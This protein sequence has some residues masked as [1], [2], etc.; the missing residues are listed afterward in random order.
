MDFNWSLLLLPFIAATIGWFTNYVAVKM[1]FNPKE[2]IKIGFFT[3][4]GIFPKRQAEI[5]VSVGKMV[6]KDLL[7]SKDLQERLADKE[8]IRLIIN[9]IEDTLDEYFEI[10]FPEKFPLLSKIISTKMRTRVKD[11]MLD[12]VELLAPQLIN[13]Q[14]NQLDKVFDVEEIVTEKVKQL[15]TEK[16]EGLMMSIIEKE[17]NFIEWVGAVLGFF[18]GLL[19]V[20]WVAIF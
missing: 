20:I 17:L 12:E 19:Q 13:N 10:K 5:A 4:H 6:A 8:N 9:K 18:I 7:N 2:P 1:L 15:S 11:E 14:V 16:L 3:L